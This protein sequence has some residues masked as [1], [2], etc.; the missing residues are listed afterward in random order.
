MPWAVAS[1]L[2]LLYIDA[3]GDPGRFTGK[4]SKFYVLAGLA[5]TSATWEGLDK[6][7]WKYFDRRGLPRPKEFKYRELHHGEPPYNKLTVEERRAL[8]PLAP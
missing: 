8:R 1:E 2:R 5:V 4:N 3:A 6:V 7:M